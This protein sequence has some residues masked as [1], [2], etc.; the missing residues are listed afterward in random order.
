MSSATNPQQPP[1]G[2][3]AGAALP[4]INSQTYPFDVVL[5]QLHKAADFDIFATPDPYPVNTDTPDDA[6]GVSGGFALNIRCQLRRFESVAQDPTKENGLRVA[7]ATGE[8]AGTFNCRLMV[9]ADDFK[10]SPGREP[11][12]VLF[13]PTI[14]Q[15]FS[16]L[17]SEF[18]FGD[19]RDG[20][21]GYAY[22]STLPEVGRPRQLLAGAVG[23]LT[24]GYGKFEGLIGTYMLNGV[25]TR[26]FG[27]MGNITLRVLDWNGNL[28]TESELSSLT[29]IADPDPDATYIV[30]RGQKK[31]S[32][33]RSEYHFAPDGKPD[34]L[35]TPAQW[36]SAQYNF[37]AGAGRGLRAGVTVGQAIGS[38]NAVIKADLFGTVGTPGDP[39]PFTT[40][41]LY[42]FVDND[43]QTVGTIT[44]GVV[45][46][47]S[48]DLKFPALPKQAGL[49]F[50]G[51]GPIQSGTGH[52]A[53]VSGMLTVNSLI[54]IMPHAL[55]LMHV[56]RLIDPDHKFRAAFGGGR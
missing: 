19:G 25:I 36:R 20:F 29:A 24:K 18:K 11:S 27:F 13:D 40:D 1:S 2:A 8:S 51:F 15:R 44:T 6:F 37:T 28:R 55:S 12:P 4:D 10:W 22:G 14:R 42:T 35:I 21:Q 50:G 43:G 39:D 52:F 41:E 45:L 32:T 54:G 34:G 47:D 46:G 48:F 3:G 53:G 56:F 17:D 26:D 49:R 30:L 38:L 5:Y 7:Q 16:L 33:Q 23:N 31:S 9:S